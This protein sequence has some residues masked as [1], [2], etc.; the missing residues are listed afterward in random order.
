M[1]CRIG[2]LACGRH[3]PQSR[4][5]RG[6]LRHALRAVPP[7][8]CP[9]TNALSGALREIP[10][11]RDPQAGALKGWLPVQEKWS[12]L[13]SE[14]LHMPTAAAVPAEQIT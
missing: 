9:Q 3:C 11:D 4:A 5:F 6:A 10:S 7:D 2:Q 12:Q 8:R 1:A 14:A 13:V